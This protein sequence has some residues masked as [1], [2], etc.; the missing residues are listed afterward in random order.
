[1]TSIVLN[2]ELA[3]KMKN[4]GWEFFSMGMFRN[5][6]FLFQ[7]NT[8]LQKIFLQ[9]NLHEIVWNRENL[10]CSEVLKIP[11]KDVEA[12]CFA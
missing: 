11:S 3:D 6:R 9:E 7:K 1:M 2:I 4:K 12:E 5:T 8:N 10:Y